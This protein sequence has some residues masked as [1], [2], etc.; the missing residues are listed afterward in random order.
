MTV[1]VKAGYDLFIDGLR[2]QGMPPDGA[3][4]QMLLLGH[5]NGAVTVLG[6]LEDLLVS[7]ADG[8]TKLAHVQSLIEECRLWASTSSEQLR[9]LA[10]QTRASEAGDG[11]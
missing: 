3:A 10:E 9:K 11:G 5:M 1:T 4:E 2:S 6:I 8:A 7:P